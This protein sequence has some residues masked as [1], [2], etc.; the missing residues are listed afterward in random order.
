ME[1]LKTGQRRDRNIAPAESSWCCGLVLG[2]SPPLA[3]VGAICGKRYTRTG[4]LLLKSP[5]ALCI[6]DSAEATGYLWSSVL[7]QTVFVRFCFQA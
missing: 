2:L 1:N 4:S 5:A 7:D 3:P 6:R